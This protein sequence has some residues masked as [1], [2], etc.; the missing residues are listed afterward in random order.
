M[1]HIF[2][3]EPVIHI[4]DG[5]DIAI[6]QHSSAAGGGCGHRHLIHFR[7]VAAGF[8]IFRTIADPA[9][10]VR[11]VLDPGMLAGD[12]G[13]GD[14]N[15]TI[16][17]GSDPKERLLD[18]IDFSFF[19][20][21]QLLQPVEFFFFLFA[22]AAVLPD[23]HDQFAVADPVYTGFFQFDAAVDTLS[24][25]IYS[26]SAF[27]ILQ[28]QFFPFFQDPG[29]MRAGRLIIHRQLPEIVFSSADRDRILY[30]IHLDFIK[31]RIFVF[32]TQKDFFFLL[33]CFYHSSLR[34]VP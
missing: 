22:G 13:I 3:P 10:A 30:G 17:V 24:E 32:Q 9:G 2:I 28:K 25:I 23:F 4:R 26:V 12:H 15:F 21:A 1:D 33:H 5:N 20:T 8:S 14:L 31:D 16:P 34:I 7:A 19:R 18:V 27:Q 6:L 11:L 29:M